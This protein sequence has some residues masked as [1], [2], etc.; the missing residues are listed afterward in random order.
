MTTQ[1]FTNGTIEDFVNYLKT[2]YDTGQIIADESTIV[3]DD[4]FVELLTVHKG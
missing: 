4:Y 1:K 2:G 3:N